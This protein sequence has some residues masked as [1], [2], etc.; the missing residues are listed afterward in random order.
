MKLVV[1]ATTDVGQVRD[2]NEDRFLVEV[3]LRLFAV[4]DGMGGHQAGEV[5]STT[6]IE[7]LRAAIA[8][9]RPLDDAIIEANRAVYEKAS[10]DHSLTGMGTTL[11]A[12]AVGS[13]R[14]V[15]VGHVG[16]S[17]AYLARAGTF[18]QI[19]E[20]HS[21]VEEMVREG[22][23]TEDQALVHPQRSIITRALGIDA[24]IDVDLYPVELQADDRILICSDGLTDMLR[25]TEIARIL[26]QENDPQRAADALADA[27]NA[28]GGIDNVTAVVIAALPADAVADPD[29]TVVDTTVVTPVMSVTDTTALRRHDPSRPT[30]DP[31][32]AAVP[33]PPDSA[34]SAAA[35]AQSQAL[36]RGRVRRAG[37]GT[38][39]LLW[40]LVPVLLIVAVGIGALWWYARNGYYVGLDKQT[41]TIYRGVPGGLLGW[42]PTIE[43][44]TS[45]RESDLTANQVQD[46]RDGHPFSTQAGAER[47]IARLELQTSTTS[48][49]TSTTTTTLP[50]GGFGSSTSTSTTLVP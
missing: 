16:D 45:V 5:A 13:E 33:P 47:F 7:A 19:T 3:G 44:R 34:A 46:L 8:A 12:I 6:A 43:R 39:R 48:T 37:K 1:G 49:S 41:V 40:W 17:R 11:T 26:R 10:T 24:E 50:P 29:S 14:A 21:L 23:I 32:P 20:D 28:N 27:A 9:G 42:D 4:A 18:E 36:R 30:V 31:V 2:G 15:V 25:P 35:A 22:R 38:F